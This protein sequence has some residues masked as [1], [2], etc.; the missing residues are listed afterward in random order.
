MLKEYE[1]CIIDLEEVMRLNPS[2]FILQKLSDVKVSAFKANRGSNAFEV[3]GVKPEA[4]ESEVKK[5]FHKLALLYHPDK[6]RGVT[7]IEEKKLERKF[8]EAQKAYNFAM[9]VLK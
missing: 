8:R 3:L 4:T 5:A 7:P 2:N 6:S 1:D 9:S